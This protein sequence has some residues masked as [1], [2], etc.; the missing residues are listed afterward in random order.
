VV[1]TNTPL[2][3]ATAT[4]A[5][6]AAA[7]AATPTPVSEAALA[8]TYTPLP[9]AT[10]RPTDTPL[11]PTYTPTPTT[12]PTPTSPSAA[13]PPALAWIAI[14]GGNF[15]MGS[16]DA[17]MQK[18]L[19][20]CNA[21]EGSDTG[22][23]C[24]AGWF[25]EPQR[26]VSVGDFQIARD[27]TTNAQY[28]ACVAAGVCRKAGEHITDNNIAYD[29]GFFADA[30]PV[31]GVS[32]NDATTFCQWVGGRLP[33]EVEWERAARG[34]DGRRYPWGDTFD[35]S[36]ANLGSGHPSP[37]GSFPAGASPYGVLDMAG[38]VF[39][40]TATQEGSTYVIRGGGWSKYYFRGRVADRGTQ[41]APDFANYDIGFRCAR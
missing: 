17:D 6:Q 4:Q 11:A 30:Y 24:Q 14:P 31:V 9:T 16:S 5:P 1:P 23:P 28:N 7:P 20:E 19:D 25:K 40:W 34:S 13:Y 15:T 35:P 36:R 3:P 39:E 10:P 12:P 2:P 41:L 38:N 26:T 21:T 32:W 8:P 33:T 29:A 18:T 37:V 22:Q 27:E